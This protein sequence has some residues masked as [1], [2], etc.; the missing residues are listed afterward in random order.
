MSLSSFAPMMQVRSRSIIL[1]NQYIGERKASILTNNKRHNLQ[2]E[3]TYSGQMTT[4]AKKRLAKAISLLNQSSPWKKVQ[5]SWQK[6]PIDFKLSF[7]TLTIP[8]DTPITGK[9][10]YKK[11]LKPFLRKCKSKFGLNSYIWKAELQARGQL[12]YHITSN[13]FMEYSQVQ[14]I[15]NNIIEVAGLM[16][17]FKS[18]HGHNSPHSTEIRAVKNVKNIEAYLVKYISK[19]DD[20][21]RSVFGKTWGCS[22]N[23]KGASY[24]TEIINS[25]NEKAIEMLIDAKQAV[26]EAFERFS[27]VKFLDASPVWILSK[28][29]QSLYKMHMASIANYS[30]PG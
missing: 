25:A 2:A 15:W 30:G 28:N 29:Q 26:F 20:A 7:C 12:H 8:D 16:D 9:E 23:L 27:I 21:G 11:L 24:F 22:E 1:F 18:K 3:K 10:A 6:T 17:V 4:H 13:C 5:P 19:S 14:E